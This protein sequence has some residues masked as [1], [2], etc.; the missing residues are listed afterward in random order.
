VLAR[1]GPNWLGSPQHVVV[2]AIL[3]VVVYGLARWQRLRLP[4]WE[5]FAI[6]V[7]VVSTAEI[8]LEL[9]EYPLLYADKFHYSAYYDT[10][11]DMASSVVGAVIGTVIAVFL[12]GVCQSRLSGALPNWRRPAW[13]GLPA[14]EIGRLHLP[15][16]HGRYIDRDLD[17]IFC[18]SLA[19]ECICVGRPNGASRR[20]PASD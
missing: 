5:T 14:R 11:A 18:V 13:A 16:R 8:L 6:A 12:P 3:A 17:A 20:L 15:I 2:G 4:E 1:T 7:G 19:K 9:A 10:L